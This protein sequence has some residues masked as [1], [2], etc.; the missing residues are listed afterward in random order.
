MEGKDEDNESHAKEEGHIVVMRPDA[1]IILSKGLYRTC[2][3][4]SL[5]A[6][7]GCIE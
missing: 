4:V 2:H 3:R 1:F 7:G 6:L 5:E